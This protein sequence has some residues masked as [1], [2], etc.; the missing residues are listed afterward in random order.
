MLVQLARRERQALVEGAGRK[1]RL[2]APCRVLP[3]RLGGQAHEPRHVCHPRHP[4]HALG[5][6]GVEEPLVVAVQELLQGPVTDVG[7]GHLQGLLALLA[8]ER[9]QL[10]IRRVAREL[11]QALQPHHRRELPL[12]ELVLAEVREPAVTLF[13]RERP[14][15]LGALQPFEGTPTRV[16]HLHHA[17]RVGPEPLARHHHRPEHDLRA[18]RHGQHPIALERLRVPG[19]RLQR[20]RRGTQRRRKEKGQGQPGGPLS[21]LHE[22]PPQGRSGSPPRPRAGSLPQPPPAPR[23]R[24]RRGSRRAA[25]RSA[26]RGRGPRRRRG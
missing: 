17:G 11:G 24:P 14:A 26:G 25:R 5:V 18:A 10:A 8:L 15:H 13:G 6:G 9:R 20:P 23:R 2:S 16:S 1:G 12:G 21:I 4:R 19:G 22:W 7:Q 3:L